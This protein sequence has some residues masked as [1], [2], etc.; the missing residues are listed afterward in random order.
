VQKFHGIIVV[1]LVMTDET[2]DW[3]FTA[4]NMATA[5]VIVG[6]GLFTLAMCLFAR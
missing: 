4:E 1:M 2:M 5:T 6:F 3:M